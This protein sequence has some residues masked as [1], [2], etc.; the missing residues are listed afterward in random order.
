MTATDREPM[1]R[2]RGPTDTC[3]SRCEWWPSIE[4]S[5]SDRDACRLCKHCLRE[6]L[7]VLAGEAGS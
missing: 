7:A 5:W 1:Y 6:A 4:V 3:C 2:F